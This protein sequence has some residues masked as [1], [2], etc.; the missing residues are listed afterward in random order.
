MWT[1][2]R[3]PLS[4]D[5]HAKIKYVVFFITEKQ[6]LETFESDASMQTRNKHGNTKWDSRAKLTDHVCIF[7]NRASWIHILDQWSNMHPLHY[8]QFN[9]YLKEF[10]IMVD[11]LFL[12]HITTFCKTAERP[13]VDFRSINQAVS[14]ILIEGR[15]CSELIVGFC[16]VTIRWWQ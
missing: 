16:I 15:W 10:C 13:L 4:F 1:M 11:N 6:K 3:S 5:K 14:I 7:I 8:L 12:P 9:H 2:N